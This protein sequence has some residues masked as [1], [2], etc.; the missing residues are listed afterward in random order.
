MRKTYKIPLAAHFNVCSK[1]ASSK[2]IVGL[3][4]PNSSVMTFKFV[5]P[6]ALRSFLPVR[7]LPV[8]P[9]FRILGCALMA[10]PATAPEIHRQANKALR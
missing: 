6:E 2:I 1:S 5:S 10:A 3:F 7:R 9:T 8:N 4:P